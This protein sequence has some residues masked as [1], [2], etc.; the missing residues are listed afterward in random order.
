MH[1]KKALRTEHKQTTHR[2]VHEN[3][4]TINAIPIAAFVI[5]T[6][7]HIGLT[8]LAF[9]TERTAAFVV[10]HQILQIC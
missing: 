9:P 2:T 8:V 4:E 6:V 3:D 10:V 5:Q 1:R 7:I